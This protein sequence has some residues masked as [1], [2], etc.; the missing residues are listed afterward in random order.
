M[1]VTRSRP[2]SGRRGYYRVN[3]PHGVSTIRS[4]SRFALGVIFHDAR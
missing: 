2:L 1:F 3:V 4:G